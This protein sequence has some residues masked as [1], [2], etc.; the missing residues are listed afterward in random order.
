LFFLPLGYDN[1]EL[2]YD[3]APMPFVVSGAPEYVNHTH[4]SVKNSEAIVSTVSNDNEKNANSN[5][6]SAD[7]HTFKNGSTF[8]LH[9]RRWHF[10]TYLDSTVYTNRPTNIISIQ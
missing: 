6:D 3:A 1:T 9:S 10:H 4:T 8:F 5:C 7:L 2:K